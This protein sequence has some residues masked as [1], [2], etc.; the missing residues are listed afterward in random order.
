MGVQRRL[1]SLVEYEFPPDFPQRLALLKEES[2]LSWRTIAR[3]LGV[4][5]HRLRQWRTQGVAPNAAHLFLL[6]SI[7]ESMGLRNGILMC[8]DRDLP[9]GL[10]LEALQDGMLESG[11]EHPEE[12]L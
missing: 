11:G 6:L 4:S 12:T 9:Q 7:A 10:D 3:L 8:P 1:Y 5:P 2:G